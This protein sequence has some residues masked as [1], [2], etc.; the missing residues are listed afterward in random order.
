[1]VGR[2]SSLAPPSDFA[3][4]AG[5]SESI[6]RVTQRPSAPGS[7]TLTTTMTAGPS[8]PG[9]SSAPTSST[10]ATPRSK[11]ARATQPLPI[12]QLS[13]ATRSQGSQSPSVAPTPPARPKSRKS[14]PARPLSLTPDK[15]RTRSFSLIPTSSF[16]R[17]I[18][19][20][21]AA[22]SATPVPAKSPLAVARTQ[23][24]AARQSVQPIPKR[25]SPVPVKEPSPSP[26][27]LHFRIVPYVEIPVRMVRKPKIKLPPVDRVKVVL[28]V[29][30]ATRRKLI[31][32]GGYGECLPFCDG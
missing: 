18:R 22:L 5:M 1:M 17:P 23:R 26:A 20:T 25:K 10:S 27:P 2:A 19:A 21:H 4:P 15:R 8:R 29:H 32:Q 14:M 11:K 31:E 9:V 30:P 6:S 28:P 7:A 13:R 12:S 24:P 16:G 3:L